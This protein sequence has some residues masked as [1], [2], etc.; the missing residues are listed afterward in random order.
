MSNILFALSDI[1]N[2][3]KIKL[4]QDDSEESIIG[5]V[6]LNRIVGIACNNLDMSNLNRET[7]KTLSILNKNYENQYDLFIK[8]LCFVIDILKDADFL[9]AFLKGSYLT[10]MLYKKG[11]RISNDLDILIRAD[12][13]SKMQKLLQKNGFVQGRCDEYGTIIEATRREIIESKM[14]YGETVP[15]LRYLENDLIEIDLNFSLDYKAQGSSEIVEDFLSK[16]INVQYGERS[17]K[18][19][20]SVDFLI[21]LCCHL[22]K[23]ASTYDWVINRRDLMLYKFSDINLFLNIFGDYNFFEALASRIKNIEC[24]IPCYYT[25]VFT[26][27]I[28]PNIRSLHGFNNML[29]QIKPLS[30][31]YLKQIVFPKIQKIYTYEVDFDTWFSSNNRLSLLKEVIKGSDSIGR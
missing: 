12:D 29:D 16:T 27:Y 22:Y 9:Y 18:T 23:E 14:N 3:G 26:S 20:A 7:Q 25:F 28:Y 10:P 17:I 4:G 15:F 21:H 8:K 6:I 5:G 30:T 24:L 2:T 31:E 13:V 11:E 19:L 1:Y